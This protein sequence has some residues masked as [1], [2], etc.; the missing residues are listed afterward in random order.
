MVTIN[1]T[2]GTVTKNVEYYSIGHFSKFVR[3]GAHRIGASVSSPV[4]N[5]DFVAFVN[6]DNKRVIVFSNAGST[7]ESVTVKEGEK[8]FTLTIP[9]NSVASIVWE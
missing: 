7:S 2:T 1:T 6:A 8:Q 9:A 5:V 3:N 4:P